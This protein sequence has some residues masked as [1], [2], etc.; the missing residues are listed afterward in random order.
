MGETIYIVGT[1][2]DCPIGASRQTLARQDTSDTTAVVAAVIVVIIVL[3][4]VTLAAKYGAKLAAVGAA[5]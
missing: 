3:A 2:D 1:C 4:V 5:A